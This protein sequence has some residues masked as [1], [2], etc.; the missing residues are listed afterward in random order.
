MAAHTPGPST[1]P[2]FRLRW[3]VLAL[4]A[5]AFAAL[6]AL[7]VGSTDA[8]AGE[9]PLPVTRLVDRLGDVLLP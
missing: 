1:G 8:E 4:P 9:Q 3:W 5:V 6:L 2:D 7:L